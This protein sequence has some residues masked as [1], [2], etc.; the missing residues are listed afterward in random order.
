MFPNDCL[1]MLA[2]RIY[3]SSFFSRQILLTTRLDNI[4]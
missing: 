2:K 4:G 3:I 1:Q